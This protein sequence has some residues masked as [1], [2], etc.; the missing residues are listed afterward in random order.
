MEKENSKL[1]LIVSVAVGLIVIIGSIFAY[2][3]V[4]DLK[5]EDIL[6]NEITSLSKKDFTKDRYNTSLKTKDDYAVIEDTI[7]AYFDE[8]AT[9]LQKLSNIAKDKKMTTILSADN[10]QK[11]GPEFVTTR[12]YLTST[13][14]NFNQIVD[15]LKKMTTEEEIMKNIEGKGLDQYY[16]DLYKDLMLG[17]TTKKDF[18]LSQKNL[19]KLSKSINGILDTEQEVI[20]LLINEKGKW[21][22]KDDKIVFD[23][24]DT[25]TK[26][27]ELIK[28]YQES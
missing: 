3:L 18:K 12:K 1:I 16:I 22:I 13:K 17:E 5:Q 14:S 26:Y 24:T 9:N 20:D 6:R 21:N 10:Y 4:R 8:Y 28:A 7:K 27:N 23:N 11:D 15:K 19:E 2:I 25:L